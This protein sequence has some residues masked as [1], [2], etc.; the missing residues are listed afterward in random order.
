M[1]PILLVVVPLCYLLGIA[2]VSAIVDKNK[3]KLD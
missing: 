1:E 2:I 3:D